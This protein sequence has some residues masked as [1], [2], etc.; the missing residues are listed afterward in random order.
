[1]TKI[2]A[3]AGRKQSGKTSC[4]RFIESL[5]FRDFQYT[6]ECRVYSFADTLK[7]D[8]CIDILGL[9][10][11]QCYGTDEEKNTLTCLEWK[12]M[13]GYNASWTL[14]KDYDETGFMTAR[15]VMQF[16]GTEIFRKMKKDVWCQA[17]INKIKKDDPDIAVIADC[18]FPNEVESIKSAGGYVI[19]LTRNP[20]NSEHESEVALDPQNYSHNNFDLIIDNNDL[21]IDQQN[22]IIYNFLKS[23]RILPL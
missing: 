23:K 8:I 13:P 11:K 5:V 3:F 22:S 21:N 18:R 12:N 4:A 10:D 2:I 20:Y 1:M 6:T 7:Q 16:V 19:K 17:T 9:T 14:I 15:Q